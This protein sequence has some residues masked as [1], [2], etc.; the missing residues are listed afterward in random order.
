ML[1]VALQSRHN[2]TRCHSKNGREQ[3]RRVQGKWHNQ[4]PPRVGIIVIPD[5][6]TG[7]NLGKMVQ[8]RDR[9]RLA[10]M[11]A[12]QRPSRQCK[13]V[14]LRSGSGCRIRR[15]PLCDYACLLC[16]L[17]ALV[18]TGLLTARLCGIGAI[19][20]SI[21]PLTDRT[22]HPLQLFLVAGA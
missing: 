9:S 5:Q 13:R 10:Q 22:T 20:S 16:I 17:N 19:I 21:G 4:V 14:L 7:N 2:V 11:R 8:E 12:F 18:L 1:V 3:R 15:R 6:L